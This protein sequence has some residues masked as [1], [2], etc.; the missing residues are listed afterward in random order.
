MPSRLAMYIAA[1]ALRIS[2]S[3]PA[4][5]SPSAIEMPRLQPTNSSLPSSRSGAR[6][7][8][9]DPL[10]GVGGVLCAADVLE[11]D[12]ELVAAEA[13]GGVA[14]ADAGVQALGD[15][16]QHRVAGGVAEAVVDR[17]EVVEVHEDHG[18]PAALAP[19]PRD[20]VPHPLDEQRAVG[21]VGDRIVEGLVCELLLERLA[22]AH[23]AAVEHDAVDVLVVEQIRVEH[24]ELADLA[25][26]VAEAAL[27]RLRAG[28]VRRGIGQDMRQTALLAGLQEPL[29]A[30]AD[31]LLGRVA[32][33]PL[34]RRALVDDQP[35]RVEDRDE[36]A[37]RA[38]RASRS[39]PRS[40]GGGPP[41]SGPR[42]RARATPPSPARRGCSAAAGGSASRSRSRAGRASRRGPR[43]RAGAWTP[44][45]EGRAAPRACSPTGGAVSRACRRERAAR[46]RRG[47]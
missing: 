22:L 15:L 4:A 41:R 3:A 18:E 28:G 38:G 20:R 17:L 39:A 6:E 31:E 40:C 26:L 2:S 7:R 43:A 19:G 21:E 37:R 29:E 32:E 16:Q 46:R 8:F 5:V 34:D 1:S 24:L 36:V 12:G 13:G 33:D 42:S 14:R 10:G 23:V 27:E 47:P 9:E 30:G 35:G 44:R 25:V 11:Q 45:S